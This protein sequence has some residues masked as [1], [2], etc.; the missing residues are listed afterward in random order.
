MDWDVVAGE[1]VA[2]FS[3]AG[4]GTADLGAAGLGTAGFGA[5][6]VSAG[7]GVTACGGVSALLSTPTGL[8]AATG[9]AA[10]TWDFLDGMAVPDGAASEIELVC[11]Q[12]A[13]LVPLAALEPNWRRVTQSSSLAETKTI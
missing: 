3:T 2:A 12:G 6:G 13:R 5:E 10:L 1:V 7:A 11:T 4:F 8:D 9:S